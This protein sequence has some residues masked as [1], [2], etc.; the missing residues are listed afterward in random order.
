MEL[1]S[2]ENELIGQWIFEGGKMIKDPVAKRI[3]WL[4]SNKLRKIGV[5]NSGWEL[6]F[7]DPESQRLWELTYPNSGLQGGGPPALISITMQ[8]AKAKYKF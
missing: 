3:D 1:S 2:G 4:V 5:A 7:V 8:E 6:L